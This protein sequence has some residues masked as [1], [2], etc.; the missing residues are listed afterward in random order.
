MFRK[1]GQRLND[2]GGYIK[3]HRG[4]S[5]LIGGGSILGTVGI[6]QALSK[7]EQEVLLDA[8]VE[9]EQGGGGEVAGV[10]STTLL[11]AAAIQSIMDDDTENRGGRK[12]V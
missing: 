5:A 10:S 3:E 1:V 7:P 8:A 11:A 9:A 6:L 12:R 2:V 4:I